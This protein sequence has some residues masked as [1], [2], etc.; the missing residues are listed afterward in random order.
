MLGQGWLPAATVPVAAARL[1]AQLLEPVPFT[2]IDAV[3]SRLSIT[4][5]MPPLATAVDVRFKVVELMPTTFQELVG[6]TSVPSTYIVSWL[7]PVVVSDEVMARV[8]AAACDLHPSS[9]DQADRRD[10]RGIATG[11]GPWQQRIIEVVGA[12]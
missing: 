10:A 1:R 11:V 8:L 12:E 4:S 5:T 6:F 3:R 2:T 9:V 7:A